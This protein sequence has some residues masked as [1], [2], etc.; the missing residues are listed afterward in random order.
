MK[1]PFNLGYFLAGGGK[2][3]WYKTIGYGWRLA[4]VIVILFLVAIGV[5]SLF[6][7]K[8]VQ[9]VTMGP[10][11]SATFIQKT[12]KRFAIF[13]EPYVDQASDHKFGTGVR[14]GVRWEW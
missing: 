3:A 1:G 14:G 4:I 11:S 8:Q 10:G 12:G 9:N 7:K 5:K 2:E 6:G 13:V